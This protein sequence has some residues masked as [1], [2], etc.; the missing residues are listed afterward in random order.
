VNSNGAPQNGAEEGED[1][2]W[3]HGELFYTSDQGISSKLK[4]DIQ[5]VS[6]LK[7]FLH[8]PFIQLSNG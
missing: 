4:A 1:G 7:D 8:T 2:G 5:G 6:H 3:L